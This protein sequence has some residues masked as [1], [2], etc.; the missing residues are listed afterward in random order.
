MRPSWRVASA[1]CPHGTWEFGHRRAGSPQHPSPGART[2]SS[3]TPGSGAE[4]ES[5]FLLGQREQTPRAYKRL[6]AKAK[7]PRSLRESHSL[8]LGCSRPGRQPA[9]KGRA[10]SLVPPWLR[11]RFLASSAAFWK[12]LILQLLPVASGFLL[13]QSRPVRDSRARRAQGARRFWVLGEQ[14]PDLLP[15]DTNRCQLPS[16]AWALAVLPGSAG[17][18][19]AAHTPR[20]ALP[21]VRT[22]GHRDLPA[23]RDWH[24]GRDG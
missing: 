6:R 19:G 11:A 14:L 2:L 1:R 4:R 15:K 20:P 10:V 8:G 16:G 17:T 7:T 13:T 23:H 22:Q 24:T 9:S 21:T 12:L 5:V 3:L 18:W